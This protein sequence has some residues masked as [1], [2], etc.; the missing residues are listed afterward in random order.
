MVVLGLITTKSGEVETVEAL[1]RRLEEAA[2]FVDLDQV[3]LSP[4]CGFASG[5]GGNMLSETEQWRK[6]E[7]LQE[8]A[9]RVWGG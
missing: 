2:R 3:A 8:T 7:V 5:I 9:R 1:L 6:I 4:Q